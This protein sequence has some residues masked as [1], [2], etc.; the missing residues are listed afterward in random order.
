MFTAAR[1]KICPRF[2][3]SPWAGYVMQARAWH[4]TG[5]LGVS[6]VD[7][8]MWVKEAFAILDS[9]TVKAMTFKRE[10]P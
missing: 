9:E 3:V 7:A 10:N 4:E 1:L 5:E 2:L 8:P 6:F